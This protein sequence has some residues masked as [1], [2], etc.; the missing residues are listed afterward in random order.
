M[1]AW[2]GGKEWNNYLCINGRVWGAGKRDGKRETRE[3]F[4]WSKCSRYP[5]P[6]G[7][8]EWVVYR[9]HLYQ[10]ERVVTNLDSKGS[11]KGFFPAKDYYKYVK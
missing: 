5:R 10:G 6:L 3:A 11:A 9:T 1:I 2:A 8:R 4:F 7:H